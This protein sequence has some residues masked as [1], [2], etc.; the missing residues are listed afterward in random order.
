MN[1]EDHLPQALPRARRADAGAERELT[2]GAAPR[3]DAAEIDRCQLC[4][5]ADRRVRFQD[6]PYRVVECAGCGR[7]Y[8][9]P[10][11]QGEALRAVYDEGYWKS[12]NPKQRGY[13]DYASEA[14]LYLKTFGKR[15]ALVR[16]HLPAKA[17]ILDVGCAAGYFLRVAQ[18][19]GH[20]VHGVEMSTAIAGE[21]QKALGADRVHVGTLDEAIAAKGLH[22]RTGVTKGT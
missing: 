22:S 10:R 20:D 12:A 5:G 6:G 3:A 21:A 17:R 9:T 15:M 14:A 19:L 16:R 18:R 4:G 2:V 7:V 8:V 11:L 1:E 13:A